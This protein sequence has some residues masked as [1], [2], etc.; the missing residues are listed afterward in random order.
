MWIMIAGPY[1]SGSS[2]PQAW[3]Q[4]LRALNGAAHAVF[5]KGHVPIIGVNL[6]LPIIES[7]GAGSY[8]R[9]MNPL[10]LQIAQRC[11]AVLRIGGPSKGADEEVETFR[12]RALPVFESLD[13]VPDAAGMGANRET[14]P[15]PAS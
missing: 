13:D 15:Q 6:A 9:I 1:R 7:A 12:T 2:D 11:D 5:N 4:N 10:S 3:E 8:E 14:G